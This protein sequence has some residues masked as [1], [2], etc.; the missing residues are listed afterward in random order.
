MQEIYLFFYF[1]F[2]DA[3]SLI[4]G[5][6]CF[7]PPMSYSFS[8]ASFWLPV[9]ADAKAE[10]IAPEKSI[11]VLWSIIE[12]KGFLKISCFMPFGYI[13]SLHACKLDISCL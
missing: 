8:H 5:L 13:S 4:K 6:T 7:L 10:I 11:S 12:I 3:Y 2:S 9:I 1:W